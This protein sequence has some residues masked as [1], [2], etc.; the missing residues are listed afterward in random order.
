MVAS[1][2]MEILHGL[3][4]EVVKEQSISVVRGELRSE[5]K[6]QGD[7]LICDILINDHIDYELRSM[8]CI[9]IVDFTLFFTYTFFLIVICS[10]FVHF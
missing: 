1:I 4:T 5:V 7:L 2:P 9:I 3:L 6:L 10:H 8:V